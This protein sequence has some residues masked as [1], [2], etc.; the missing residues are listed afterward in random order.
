MAL[1]ADQISPAFLIAS[2]TAGNTGRVALC[3]RPTLTRL[4]TDQKPVQQH[5]FAQHNPC[6]VPHLG[7][8]EAGRLTQLLSVIDQ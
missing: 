2:S 3:S 5:Y 1:H 4:E 7:N 6:G 8:W